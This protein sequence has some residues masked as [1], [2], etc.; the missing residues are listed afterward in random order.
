MLLVLLVTAPCYCQTYGLGHVEKAV[1]SVVE[2]GVTYGLTCRN[3]SVGLPNRVATKAV[4]SAK[5]PKKVVTTSKAT[6]VTSV[7]YV[8]P[9]GYH[10]HKYSDG[11]VIEH[12]DWNYGDPVAHAGLTGNWPKYYGPLPP[13]SP[14]PAGSAVNSSCPN[15]VCPAPTVI[16]TRGFF[17]R[18]VR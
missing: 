8:S 4:T 18:W 10:R 2:S 13:N 9:P 17:R 6:K 15:G 12:E 14:S 1:S 7:P 16:R 5:A 3:I 11:R